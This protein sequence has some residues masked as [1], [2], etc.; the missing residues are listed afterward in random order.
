VERDLKKKRMSTWVSPPA[1]PASAP[2]AI[3][4]F[5]YVRDC[6]AAGQR[7][8][9]VVLAAAPTAAAAAA[10]ADATGMPVEC[11]PAVESGSLQVPSGVLW[12]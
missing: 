4:C 8:L 11:C 1:A 6:I 7:R 9:L 12:G 10:A 3:I 2:S 5:G